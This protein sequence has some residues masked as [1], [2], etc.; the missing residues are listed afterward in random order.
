MPP[1][2]DFQGAKELRDFKASKFRD[3]NFYDRPRLD[4][5]IIKQAQGAFIHY[6][7]E[8]YSVFNRYEDNNGV[9]TSGEQPRTPPGPDYNLYLTETV[10]RTLVPNA[11][12]GVIGSSKTIVRHVDRITGAETSTTSSPTRRLRV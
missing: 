4:T 1:Q 7:I 12:L 3:R 10:V 5:F 8:E 2:F 11:T 9:T 6:G